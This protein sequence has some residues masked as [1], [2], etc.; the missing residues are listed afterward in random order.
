MVLYWSYSTHTSQEMDTTG[1]T[2][3]KTKRFEGQKKIGERRK[4]Q[5]KGD[6]E[7]HTANRRDTHLT[8]TCIFL[9]FFLPIGIT[10]CPTC[11]IS[12]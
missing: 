6:F 2:V 7:Y 1:H 4:D 3:V 5:D 12:F 11:S 9:A 8:H 10:F